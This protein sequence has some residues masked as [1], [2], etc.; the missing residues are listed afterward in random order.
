MPN[1]TEHDPV[2]DEITLTAVFQWHRW[3]SEHRAAPYPSDQATEAMRDIVRT[4]ADEASSAD[5]RTVSADPRLWTDGH[6]EAF[7]RGLVSIQI[8]SWL[9]HVAT[10]EEQQAAQSLLGL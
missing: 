8:S 3:R 5:L 7:V 1:A 10:V 4:L 2:L 6:L 9:K